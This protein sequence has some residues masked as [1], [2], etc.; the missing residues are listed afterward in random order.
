[1][2]LVHPFKPAPGTV[3]EPIAG[4]E[5]K[6]APDGEILVRGPN[7]TPGYYGAERET[8]EAFEGGWFHTGDIG[9]TDESGRLVVRGRKKEMIATPEGMKV[10]PDDVERVLNELPGVHESAVVGLQHDGQER[11]HAVLSLETGTNQDDVVRQANAK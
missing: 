10:F 7:V 1:V 4:V 6:I 11:V 8:K 9:Q 3:G 2:T 5:I